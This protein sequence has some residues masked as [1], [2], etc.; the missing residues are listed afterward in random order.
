MN[1]NKVMKTL[2]FTCTNG[3]GNVFFVRQKCYN[4][5]KYKPK[6]LI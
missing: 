3:E 2:V 4:M 5:L 1:Y 6:G